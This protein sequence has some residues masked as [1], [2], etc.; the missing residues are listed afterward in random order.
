MIIITGDTTL[1]EMYT[2]EETFVNMCVKRN[3]LFLRQGM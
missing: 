2:D 1:E 3:M